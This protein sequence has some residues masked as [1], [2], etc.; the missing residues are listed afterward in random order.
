MNNNE[1]VTV[2]K[3][4]TTKD[5][6][7][8]SPMKAKLS[9]AEHKTNNLEQETPNSESLKKF[10]K[11]GALVLTGAAA[12]TTGIVMEQSDAPNQPLSNEKWN[13]RIEEQTEHL[14]H[15]STTYMEDGSTIEID[16]YGNAHYYLNDTDNDGQVE[17][18]S[19][20]GSEGT[21]ERNFGDGVSVR[22]AINQLDREA[23]N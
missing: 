10:L 22:E 15:V 14:G 5:G 21:A 6:L 12:I 3:E 20:S 7:K 1:K 17:N 19:R 2:S 16:A 18:G 11:R 4:Q 8:Y 23:N 9:P 13:E